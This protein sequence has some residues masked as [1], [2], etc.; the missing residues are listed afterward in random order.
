MATAFGG[1]MERRDW[2]HRTR[3]GCSAASS[4]GIRGEAQNLRRIRLG[5]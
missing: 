1:D 2:A 3:G 5:Q 4:R